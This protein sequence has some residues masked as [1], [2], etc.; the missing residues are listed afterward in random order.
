MGARFSLA[1]A[2]TVLGS[3]TALAGER[4]AA[5]SQ[6]T[7]RS[8]VR[9][10]RPFDKDRSRSIDADELASLNESYAAAPTGPL[11]TLDADNDGHIDAAEI[12][13]LS[14][15]PPS[16]KGL[17]KFDQ[18]GNFRL[19]AEE[20]ETLRQ[21]FASAPT[22]PLRAWDRNADSRLD[23]DEI[24]KINERLARQSARQRK[25]PSATVPAA[26]QIES[27]S[28]SG[29]GSASLSWQRPTMNEDGTP[30]TNLAGY[31]IRYGRSPASLTN[32]VELSNPTLN[33]YVIDGLGTG[34]WYFSVSTITTSGTESAPGPV[35]SKNISSE[36]SSH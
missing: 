8:A 11:A 14:L 13:S 15:G 4:S 28:D 12:A 1:L 9:A 17:K 33:A 29:S 23:D 26:Q 30:L 34:I 18:D 35:V 32:R 31:V 7:D 27:Q 2:L 3:I 36:G 10:L 16:V 19:E 6:T 5:N 22:G 25:A 24:A 21:Q 20:V